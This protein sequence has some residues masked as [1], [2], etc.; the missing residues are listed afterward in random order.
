MQYNVHYKLNL[1][2]LQLLSL[3]YK[4]LYSVLSIL[5]EILTDSDLKYHCI[6]SSTKL[7]KLLTAG[8]LEVAL[9]LVQWEL[10]ELHCFT[11]NGDVAPIKKQAM[12]Y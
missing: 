5:Q 6:L 8:E 3:I 11:H 4:A 9:V 10:P 2:Y 12:N 7:H 1:K